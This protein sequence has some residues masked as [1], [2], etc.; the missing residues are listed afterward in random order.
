MSRWLKFV[1]VVLAALLS[2]S[3][4]QLR[5]DTLDQFQYT[6][7]TIAADGSIVT[8]SFVWQLPASPSS[9]DFNS[10]GFGFGILTNFLENNTPM[11]GLITFYN[12][13]VGVGGGLQID[14]GTSTFPSA[15]PLALFFGPQVYTGSESSPT[16]LP[17]TYPNLIDFALDPN[18][19]PATLT[20]TAPVPEPPSAL[21]LGSG[22]LVFAIG[23]ALKKAIN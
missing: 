8:N 5:A 10:T 23:F 1:L 2:V 3:A 13:A 22:L 6:A 12:G 9:T 4:Q 14:A 17:G 21:L 20:I 16:F 18:G 15:N 7:T 11:F 19:A